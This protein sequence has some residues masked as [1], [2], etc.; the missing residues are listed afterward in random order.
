MRYGN[1]GVKVR[2]MH[3]T[4]KEGHTRF[5]R[6]KSNQKKKSRRRE[7]STIIGKLQEL[8]ELYTRILVMGL[9]ES[10]RAQKKYSPL[11]G[12]KCLFILNLI[13]MHMDG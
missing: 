3:N 13:C 7:E 6:E 2:I 4:E 8:Q 12:G 1:G 10:K 9:V 5:L 11:V